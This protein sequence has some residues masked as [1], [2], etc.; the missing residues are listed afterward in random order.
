MA[1]LQE[2]IDLTPEQQR[3]WKRLER[4][5]RDFRAAG[6]K[7]Y[8]VLDTLSGYNGEHV[9]TIDNDTGYHTASVYMPSIDAP[10]F[11]SWADDWHGITLNEGVEVEDD[12]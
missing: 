6:G 4:A 1:T 11:T 10:G 5:V 3:A 7:F 12:Q 2:L 9:A 8:S